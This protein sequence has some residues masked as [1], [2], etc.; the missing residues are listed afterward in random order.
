MSIDAYTGD[1]LWT[2]N[3]PDPEVIGSWSS[4][5]IADGCIFVGFIGQKI[6]RPFTREVLCIG[7]F[8]T[9]SLPI[10]TATIV[11]GSELD[12]RI[13]PGDLVL[14]YIQVYNPYPYTLQNVKVTLISPIGPPTLDFPEGTPTPIGIIEHSNYVTNYVASL[15]K[16]YGLISPNSIGGDAPSQIWYLQIWKT[17]EKPYYPPEKMPASEILKPVP[18]GEYKL[19]IEVEWDDPSG[20]HTTDSTLSIYVDYPSFTVPSGYEQYVQQSTYYN[21]DLGWVKQ[22][23]AKAICGV[24][25][26]AADTTL[27]AC[28]NIFRWVMNYFKSTWNRFAWIQRSPDYMTLYRMA[29]EQEAGVCTQCAEVT[30]AL[31]RSVGIPARVV[32]HKLDIPYL[33]DA[34]HES[35]EAFTE[36]HWIQVD[37]ATGII[38]WEEPYDGYIGM[39]AYNFFGYGFGHVR[40]VTSYACKVTDC[41]EYDGWTHPPS[42]W[43]FGIHWQD[44]SARYNSVKSSLKVV[45]HS[46]FKLLVTDSDGA[47]IGYDLSTG[48]A[49]NYIGDTATYSGTESDPQ[50]IVILNP[51]SGEYNIKLLGVGTGTFTLT[52]ETNT[53]IGVREETYSGAILLGEMLTC[54]L[55]ISSEEVEFTSPT[56]IPQNIEQDKKAMC[57]HVKEE[58]QWLTTVIK[59]LDINEDVKQG[60]LDKL[61]S[62][63]LKVDQAINSLDQSK[64]KQGDNML[65]AAGNIL[66]SFVRLV[67]AQSGKAL[68]ESDGASLIQVVKGIID[69]IERTMELAT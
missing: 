48:L 8:V 5:V 67:N 69:D 12:N 63:E 51:P 46:P 29:N 31:L 1:I 25:G 44:V 60:L 40:S 22:A 7:G 50:V 33:P 11:P 53:S 17:L 68:K 32:V 26:V 57:N 41:L 20:H 9:P 28:Q 42:C 2:Y 52:I 30:V 62:A 61:S 15:T 49:I 47:T 27:D 21:P 14:Y 24:G 39:A 38:D 64:Q 56:R 18:I 58:L 36:N 35:A 10:I 54:T 13:T 37:P 45:G 6:D 55:N 16:N 19:T 3:Y 23:A 34:W 65:N 4:P 59:S 43:C 66:Q